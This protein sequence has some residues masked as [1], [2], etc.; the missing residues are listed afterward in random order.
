MAEDNCE[1][2]HGNSRE[3]KEGGGRRGKGKK[4]SINSDDAE[5]QSRAGGSKLPFTGHIWP[6]T[7]F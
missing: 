2:L 7:C 5:T 4:A 3:R 6:F 1:I